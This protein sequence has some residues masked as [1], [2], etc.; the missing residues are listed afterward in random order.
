VIRGRLVADIKRGLRLPMST[1]D[2]EALAED[3][4]DIIEAKP[5]SQAQKAAEKAKGVPAVLWGAITGK[6]KRAKMP[7]SVTTT[8]EQRTQAVGP[9]EDTQGASP[10]PFRN[11]D[12]AQASQS[13]TGQDDPA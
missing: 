12:E 7:K 3:V 8:Y 1:D 11:Q 9:M 6:R 2:I 4:P 5:K 10:G 13:S